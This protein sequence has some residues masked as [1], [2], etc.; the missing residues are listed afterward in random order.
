MVAAVVVGKKL[1][2]RSSVHFTG[3]PRAP[4][5][6]AVYRCTQGTRRPS[7]RIRA[8]DLAGQDAHRFAVNAQR[9]GDV[10]AHSGDALRALHTD[11]REPVA[12]EGR[13]R[14]AR[15]HRVDDDT[16]VHQIHPGNVRGLG[17]GGIDRGCIAVV[18]VEAECSAGTSS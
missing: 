14:R 6:R 7:Y 2:Q 13:D 5:P 10:R 16:A 8:A 1:P 9:F 17:K 12:V 4:C 11:E 18:I 3:R 15:L